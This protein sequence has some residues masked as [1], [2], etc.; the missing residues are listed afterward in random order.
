[1]G[2]SDKKISLRSEKESFQLF[3]RMIQNFFL[4]IEDAPNV[5][6]NGIKM[7]ELSSFRVCVDQTSW[8]LVESTN[9]LQ[10][11]K[12]TTSKARL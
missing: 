11:H 12:K 7:D 6:R 5:Q 9:N 2:M 10:Q 8:E 4:L 3:E 1:M